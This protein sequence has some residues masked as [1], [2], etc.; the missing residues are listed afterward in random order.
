MKERPEVI[1]V[2]STA[3]LGTHPIH[4]ILVPFP[5]AFLIGALVT[6][7]VYASSKNPF[8]A[9]VSYW[10]LL[11]GL[12]MG[13]LAGIMGMIDLFTIRRARSSIG[14]IHGLGNIVALILTLINFLLRYDNIAGAIFPG[15]LILSI[16]TGSTLLITGWLGGEL[17]FR[18]EVGVYPKDEL[19]EK[20]AT[21]RYSKAA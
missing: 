16:I 13:G 14:W 7:I 10:L 19:I 8:W 21:E 15:G 5:I 4:P 9:G 18:Y 11:A 17:T 6:D 20:S 3:S 1:G 12:V 2:K